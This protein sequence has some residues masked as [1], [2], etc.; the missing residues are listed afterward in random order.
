[1][2]WYTKLTG[3]GAAV[4]VSASDGCK[5]WGSFQVAIRDLLPTHPSVLVKR[6]ALYIQ[7]ELKNGVF[8]E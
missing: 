8:Q 6:S 4:T 5:G 3:R 2:R 1:M 7:Q